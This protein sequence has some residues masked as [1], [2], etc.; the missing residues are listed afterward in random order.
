MIDS[1]CR[2]SSWTICAPS[3]AIWARPAT[4]PP[5]VWPVQALVF[6]VIDTWTG[7]AIG[8]CTYLPPQ[9][10]IWGPIGT[11]AEAPPTGEPRAAPRVFPV[12]ILSMAA[13]GNSGRLLPRGSGL[14]PMTAP[15]KIDDEQFQ[16]LLD[17]TKRA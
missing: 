13:M 7:R 1:C 10:E 2:M 15:P 16:H 11:P 12:P 4:L 3:S 9:P 17:L 14:G 5:T 8:G 6:D